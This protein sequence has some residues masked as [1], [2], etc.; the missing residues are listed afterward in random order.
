MF[1]WVEKGNAISK[2][3]SSTSHARKERRKYLQWKTD[4]KIEI[5]VKNSIRAIGISNPKYS[6]RFALSKIDSDQLN[7]EVKSWSHI[8]HNNKKKAPSIIRADGKILTIPLDI[9]K[10]SPNLECS[11]DVSLEQVEL[12]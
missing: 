3:K 12:P 11:N 2:K 1:P 5:C 9:Q 7:F 6:E 10:F 4:D 8:I